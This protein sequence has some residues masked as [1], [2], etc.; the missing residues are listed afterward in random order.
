MTYAFARVGAALGC[1]VEDVFVQQRRLWIRLHE[2]GGK[3][4]EM[5][6]HHRLEEY[7]HAYI[8]GCDLAEDRKGALFRASKLHYGEIGC[9]R[10]AAAPLIEQGWIDAERELTLE[11]LFGLLTKG[12]LLQLFGVTNSAG[13]RKVLV[14]HLHNKRDTVIELLR[15]GE[16][17]PKSAKN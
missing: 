15:A 11:Q 7:L 2:K 1:R 16:I 6:C 12:E 9:P 8:D 13:L 5:P 17:Y 10:R 3:R 4:H 14:E